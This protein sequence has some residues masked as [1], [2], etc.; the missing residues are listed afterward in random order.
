M[1]K[2]QIDTHG[3]TA[4]EIRS[5]RKAS[6]FTQEEIAERFDQ[7]LRHWQQ[8]ESTGNIKNAEYEMLLLLSGKHPFCILTYK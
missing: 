1:R 6:G 2:F 3:I 7:S 5:L 8:K 4:G